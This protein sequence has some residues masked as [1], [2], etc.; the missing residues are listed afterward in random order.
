MAAGT[1]QVDTDVEVNRPAQQQESIQSGL[2]QG[3]RT[4][5][6]P[7]PVEEYEQRLAR[8]RQAMAIAQ[9]D[10]ALVTMPRDFHWLT[11]SRVDFW[12]SES[13]QWVIIGDSDPIGIVRHLEASTHRCCSILKKWVEYPDEGPI[14]PYDPVGCAVNTL[15]TLG[16]GNR[17]IGLNLRVTSVEEYT[18]FQE[19]LPA[20][21]FVDFRVERLR[22]KRSAAELA[23]IRRAVKVNQDAL[24]ETIQEM[25]VGWSEWGILRRISQKH[26]RALG[27]EYFRSPWGATSCQ[28]GRHMMHMHA[29]R[30]PTET[31]KQRIKPGDGV[32]LEPGVFVKEYVGC[33]IRT[34]WFG[35]PPGEVR[36]AVSATAEA[37][38]RLTAVL[39]PGK[40][41]GEVDAAARDFLTS[42]GLDFQHRSGY[43]ANEKWLD[44]GILSLTPQNPLL[45]EPGHV[46][47]C[48]IHVHLP[49]I[50]YVGV[51]EQ[52]LITDTGCEVLGD[53]DRS[54]PR[55]LFVKS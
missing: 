42:Q 22:V 36:H 33:M 4:F 3:P 25:R 5:P 31:R 21:Q 50:G 53:R 24:A 54:C 8:V 20:A 29:I 27:D 28:V 45:L 52:V 14:N 41:A 6:L 46:F 40:T 16:W 55:Q 44:G 10:V 7:F 51:S 35:E 32:W 23:C 1:H 26:A 9:V 18:R 37:F 15:K 39:A 12:A 38:D 11:G 34:V 13:P 47:H 43:M 48:P 17:K 49:G 2:E 19:L 30:T